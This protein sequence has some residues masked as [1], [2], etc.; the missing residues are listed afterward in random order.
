MIR[1]CKRSNICAIILMLFS[2]IG[3]GCSNSESNKNVADNVNPY[4]EFSSIDLRKELN[5]LNSK[6]LDAYYKNIN[7]FIFYSTIKHD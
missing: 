6:N 5:D 2:I 4:E 7:G 3:C 1:E